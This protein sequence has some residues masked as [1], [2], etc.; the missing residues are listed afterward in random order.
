MSFSSWSRTLQLTRPIRIL[1]F[2]RSLLVTFS[3]TSTAAIWFGRNPLGVDLSCRNVF[4]GEPLNDVGWVVVVAD[5]QHMQTQGVRTNS[6]PCV[7]TKDVVRIPVCW[8]VLSRHPYALAW[9]S[10][11]RPGSA[12]SFSLLAEGRPLRD[13]RP[14]TA[15]RPPRSFNTRPIACPSL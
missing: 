15:S 4:F 7:R 14:G 11:F 13:P 12:R 9:E 10:L 8:G 3:G 1:L 2:L 6:N 5:P